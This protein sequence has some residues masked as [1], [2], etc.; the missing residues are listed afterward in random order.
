[1][2]IIVVDPGD[3]INFLSKTNQNKLMCIIKYKNYKISYYYNYFFQNVIKFSSSVINKFK[4]YDIYHFI[5]QRKLKTIGVHIR[6]GKDGDF[7]ERKATYFTN[8]ACL[9][10]FNNTI[11]DIV[12]KYNIQYIIL[13]SDSYYITKSKSKKLIIIRN[14]F[15]S[16]K[17]KH[18]NNWY[19]KSLNNDSIEC[20]F[21]VYMLSKSKFLILT[22]NSAFSKVSYYMNKNCNNDVCKFL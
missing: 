16:H 7:H 19:F 13:S 8:M 10:H 4:N 15:K 20:L 9:I 2:N 3:L 14:L 11:K 17:L 18:S 22:K 1:M 12:R 21:E 5:N 6:L